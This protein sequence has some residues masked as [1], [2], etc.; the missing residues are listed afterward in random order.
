MF[1]CQEA[2][3]RMHTFVDR[4]LTPEEIKEVEHHL[5]RCPDCRDRFTFEEHVKLRLRH[6]CANNVKAPPSLVERISD[7][8]PSK[9]RHARR[10]DG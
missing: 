2:L 8:C 7:L 3:E 9:A 10:D 1:T 5:M 4:E 6:H